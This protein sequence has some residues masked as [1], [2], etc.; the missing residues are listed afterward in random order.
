M[1]AVCNTLHPPQSANRAL[2]PHTFLKR[3]NIRLRSTRFWTYAPERFNSLKISMAK[4]FDQLMKQKAAIDKQIAAHERKK[5]TIVAKIQR[6]MQKH[7]V[8]QLDLFGG[9]VTIPTGKPASKV[10]S[11]PKYRGTDGQAWSGKGPTPKWLKD[12]VEAGATKE[13][14]LVGAKATRSAASEGAKQPQATAKKRP[15]KRPA[16]KKSSK[17]TSAKKAPAQ[18]RAAVVKAG[19]PATPTAE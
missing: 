7:G 4:S 1:R 13:Q 8:T 15:V 16:V 9:S 11:P 18:K 10:T 12:A 5:L 17:K 6:E 19:K 3:R 2:T 14:F